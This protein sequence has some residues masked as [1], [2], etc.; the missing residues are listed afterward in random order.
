MNILVPT[1]VDAFLLTQL[2]DQV[3]LIVFFFNK[4]F[5]IGVQNATPYPCEEMVSPDSKVETLRKRVERG[6]LTAHNM[7]RQ[8][9]GISNVSTLQSCLVGGAMDSV[10]LL[11][12]KQH[13]HKVL[14]TLIF[15]TGHF[16]VE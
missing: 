9:L 8:R 2:G 11:P 6:V 14:E 3:S 12:F 1:P 7:T 15:S 16:L 10:A 5:L 13:E 4:F